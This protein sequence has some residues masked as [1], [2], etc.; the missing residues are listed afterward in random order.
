MKYMKHQHLLGIE[1]IDK[2]DFDL[3]IH[4]KFSA[5]GDLQKLYKKKILAKSSYFV[6]E[7]IILFWVH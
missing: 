4:M 6:P 3:L 5:G 7:D 1:R 2:R